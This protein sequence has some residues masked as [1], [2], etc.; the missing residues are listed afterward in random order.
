MQPR[1]VLHFVNIFTLAS[2]YNVS[3]VFYFNNVCRVKFR[4]IINSQT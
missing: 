1:R 2:K 3:K 4:K